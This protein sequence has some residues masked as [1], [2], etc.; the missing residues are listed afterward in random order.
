MIGVWNAEFL[1]AVRVFTVPF[2]VLNCT[3]PLDVCST[4]C[5]A[6]S[7]ALALARTAE[8]SVSNSSLYVK[9]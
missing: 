1:W 8:Y 9:I 2:V 5:S 4:R 3:S 6:L 7:V